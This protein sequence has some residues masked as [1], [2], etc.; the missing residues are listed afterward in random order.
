MK[1]VYFHSNLDLED[2]V[3]KVVYV[4]KGFISRKSPW[5]LPSN[6]KNFSLPYWMSKMKLNFCIPI[7]NKLNRNF[8]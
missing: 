4:L 8:I 6:C 3:D 5:S 1:L 7:L 2:F